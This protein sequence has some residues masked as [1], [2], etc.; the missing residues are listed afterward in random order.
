MSKLDFVGELSIKYL[1]KVQCLDAV[2]KH[3]AN[4]IGSMLLKCIFVM[5]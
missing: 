2:H 3:L 5:K 4:F 1:C